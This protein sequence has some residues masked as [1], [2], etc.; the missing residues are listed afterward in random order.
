M[1]G[2]P[3]LPR[4]RLRAGYGEHLAT[5]SVSASTSPVVNRGAASTHPLSL[6]PLRFKR[7]SRLARLSAQLKTQTAAGIMTGPIAR[8]MAT[9][10]RTSARL[11]PFKRL[12][13]IPSRAY[14]RVLA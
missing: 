8:R 13:R 9:A 6:Y 14:V 2:V 7:P 1:V 11:A 3:A 10:G 5:H 4:Q 12:L